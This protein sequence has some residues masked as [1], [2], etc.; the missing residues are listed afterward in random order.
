MRL[1]RQS[2]YRSLLDALRSKRGLSLAEL[3]EALPPYYRYTDD[4]PEG[5]A[6]E[7]V[8]TLV[9]WGLAEAFIGDKLVTNKQLAK[10]RWWRDDAQLAFYVSKAA[11]EME[12]L[13]GGAFL[14]CPSEVLG[15]GRVDVTRAGVADVFVIMPFSADLQTVYVGAIKPAVEFVGDERRS[16]G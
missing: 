13:I 1:G 12:E 6:F 4:P 2:S 16:R 11:L 10:L 9:R 8:C 7:H 14:S 5:V 3:S 15:S